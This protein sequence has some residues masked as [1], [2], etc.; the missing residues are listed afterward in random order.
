MIALAGFVLILLA[1][2]VLVSRLSPVTHQISEYANTGWGWL[3][4]TGFVLW[5]ASLALA[6]I[7]LRATRLP[8][9]AL[10]L[11][12]LGALL[13]A[14]FHTQTIAGRLP[15]GV[16]LS[17][18][19]RLHDIGGEILSGGI[20]AAALLVAA[21]RVLPRT[22]QVGGLL[23]VGA[24]VIADVAL[25]AA[26]DPAP[27]IRQRLL[28]LAAVAWQALILLRR[29]HASKRTGDSGLGQ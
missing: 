1:E 21:A 12:A 8:A 23:I 7:D 24:A 9:I 27:G 16:R 14:A 5:A 3:M 15:P 10:V 6:A 4:T 26:G 11:A 20:L 28:I 22:G 18:D 2:H 29:A 25:L 19:G 13:V 17:S